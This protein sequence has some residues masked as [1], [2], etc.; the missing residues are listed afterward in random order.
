MD[1]GNGVNTDDRC[2][3]TQTLR[4]TCVR[5]HMFFNAVNLSDLIVDKTCAI[6]MSEAVPPVFIFTWLSLS[7]EN[8]IRRRTYKRHASYMLKVYC[9]LVNF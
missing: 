9:V 4:C 6:I 3:Y 5:E 1:V 7:C 8:C 2:M